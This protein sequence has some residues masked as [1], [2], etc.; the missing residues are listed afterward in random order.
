ML[1]SAKQNV[2]SK[3]VLRNAFVCLLA[4]TIFSADAM[5]AF[6]LPYAQPVASKQL[7]YSEKLTK[8]EVEAFLGRKMTSMEKLGFRL[9]KKKFVA[10]TNYTMGMAAPAADSDRTNGWA[11]AGFVTSFFIGPL[12]LIFSIIALGQIKRNG[13][14]GYGLAIA[15]LVLGIIGTLGLIFLL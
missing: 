2:M 13:G 9:N 6:T 11:I 1:Y 5:A 4:A 3:F 12:G 10:L 7:E 8:K 14:R 15:G